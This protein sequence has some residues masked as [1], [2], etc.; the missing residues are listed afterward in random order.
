MFLEDGSSTSMRRAVNI[1]DFSEDGWDLPQRLRRD[2]NVDPFVIPTFQGVVS[3]E[4]V[5]AEP[6]ISVWLLVDGQMHH[7]QDLPAQ[8]RRQMVL[9]QECAIIQDPSTLE[10]ERLT[11]AFL[12]GGRHQVIIIETF[13]KMLV[14]TEIS[15]GVG[16][17]L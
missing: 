9:P 3:Q 15:K 11:H 10:P 13:G 2:P 6:I 16:M 5:E 14:L 12:E 1:L 7:L 17:E 8:G 4:T